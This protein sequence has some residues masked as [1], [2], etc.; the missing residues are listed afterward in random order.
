[1]AKD[2]LAPLRRAEELLRDGCTVE[3]IVDDLQ[4][5]FDLDFVDAM[6]AVAATTLVTKR[7]LSVP[8]RG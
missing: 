1:M 5:R 2:E 8:A 3:D 7:G 4:L 6:S